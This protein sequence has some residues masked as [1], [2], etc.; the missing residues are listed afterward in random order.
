MGRLANDG[1]LRR[2]AQQAAHVTGAGSSEIILLRGDSA[3]VISSDSPVPSTVAWS[4]SLVAKLL[5]APGFVAQ[6]SVSANAARLAPFNKEERLSSFAGISLCR[7]DGS[8]FGALAVYYPPPTDIT[9]AVQESLLGFGHLIEV[10]V[11]ELVAPRTEMPSWARSS[12]R[13]LPMFRCTLA[14]DGTVQ[15]VGP[16]WE[17]VTGLPATATVGRPFLELLLNASRPVAQ[18]LL[19]QAFGGGGAGVPSLVFSS[20]PPRSVGSV[21]AQL[22]FSEGVPNRLFLTGWSESQS[23]RPSHAS[24]RAVFEQLLYPSIRRAVQ[25]SKLLPIALLDID[26]F[27][28]VNESLGFAC[29]DRVVESVIT[30]LSAFLPIPPAIARIGGDEIAIV[31][32]ACSTPAEA[33]SHARYVIH[34]LDEPVSIEGHDLELTANLGLVLAP[35]HA[36]DPD[37][38]LR[39]AET[40]LRCVK[41]HGQNHVAVFDPRWLA[42]RSEARRLETDLARALR[43]AEFRLQFQPQVCFDGSLAGVEALVEWIHPDL[44]VLGPSRFIPI[45]EEVGRIGELGEWVLRTA[46]GCA[47][48]WRHRGVF[49]HRLAVNVSPIQFGQ[50]GFSRLVAAILQ[51]TGLPGSSLELELTESAVL[52]D[53]REARRRMDAI[54]ALGVSL[55]LDDFGVGYSSL[56]HL[57]NLPLDA[58]KIDRSFVARIASSSGSLDLIHTIVSLAH[59]RGLRIVAEGVETEEQAQ[60]LADAHCDLAQGFWFSRP[61]AKVQVE[62][63]LSSGHRW[64]SVP[65]GA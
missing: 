41:T 37:L 6:P 49:P 23:V 65:N 46:A 42:A 55:C 44:G 36:A 53:V 64:R 17:Q 47:A 34:A 1:F 32:P 24:P 56:H 3:S 13:G 57:Q 63:W 4:G 25:S 43:Q 45:A 33:E 15:E 16:S 62:G 60:F 14:L 59:N 8:L 19:N 20:E 26:G 7:T 61:A 52:P 27:S 31:L 12:E 35:I 18:T 38:L 48:D 22:L 30:R 29:G 58:V 51:E 2:M 5:D 40:A 10:W 11:Q 9:P 50:P 28:R 39:F 21:V 54:R